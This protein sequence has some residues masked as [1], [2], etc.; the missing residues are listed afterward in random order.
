MDFNGFISKIKDLNIIQ[1]IVNFVNSIQGIRKTLVMLALMVLSSFFLVKGLLTGN[2]FTDLLKATVLGFLA[3]NSVEHL[4]S[5]V[6]E[7]INSK[8]QK[9]E[10]IEVDVTD[11]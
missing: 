10:E 1:G 7:H 5:V 9:V 3:C 11:K 8:G 2:N 4:T 6:K